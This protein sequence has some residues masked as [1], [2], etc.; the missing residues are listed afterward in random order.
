MM[1]TMTEAEAIRRW[2]PM[3]QVTSIDGHPAWNRYL[4]TPDLCCASQC[5]AW[6]WIEEEWEPD[7]CVRSPEGGYT[8]SDHPPKM[9]GYCG[10]FGKPE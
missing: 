10:A 3:A 1:N 6:R 7:E 4:N 8:T 5:M 9:R 2:C